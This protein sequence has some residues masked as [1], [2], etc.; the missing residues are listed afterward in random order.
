M[1]VGLGDP[2]I[3]A[4]Q[5]RFFKT[6]PGEYGEGDRFAGVRVP[7]L[8]KLAKQLRGLPLAEVDA[9]LASGIHEV[10]QLGLFVLAVD[11]P[12]ADPTERDRRVDLYRDALRRGSVNNW[13][14][15]D[16]SADPIL[17]GWLV[18]NATAGERTA[19]A[20]AGDYAEL[21]GWARA[22]DLWQRRAGLIGTFAFIKA[23]RSDAIYAVA[24]IVVADRRDLIQK[25]F[26]W[27][28]RE[29]GKRV[30]EAEL[31]DYLDVHAGELGRTALSYATERLTAEQRRYFRS[32]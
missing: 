20:C 24:P 19:G 2:E 28:L 5:R 30:D 23:G 21:L 25:A 11:F 14:L 7:V 3:A 32:R 4:G 17:G 1:V 15:V 31:L 29:A 26:G 10:R 8:R 12:R 27:M 18:G 9:L 6:G 16:C 22:D 13:D